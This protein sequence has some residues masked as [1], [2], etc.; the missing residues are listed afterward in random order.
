MQETE[1][2]SIEIFFCCSLE[3]YISKLLNFIS[4]FAI[5]VIGTLYCAKGNFEFGISRIIK[6]RFRFISCQLIDTSH[7]FL[8]LLFHSLFV[9]I[10]SLP[11]CLYCFTPSLSLL[12]HSFFVST[13]SLLLCLYCFTP[14][15][16]LLS[17]SLFVSTVS[18]PISD[19]LSPIYNFFGTSYACWEFRIPGLIPI[20]LKI[21]YFFSFPLFS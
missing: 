19:N 15:L 2:E 3:T 6:V 11:L 17:H 4:F 20:F 16:S 9:S 12:F 5:T 7:P 14:S 13:V 18:L 1:N 21:F 10:V 8:S